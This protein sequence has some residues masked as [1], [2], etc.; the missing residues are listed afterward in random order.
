MRRNLSCE[1]VQM[2]AIPIDVRAAVWPIPYTVV[3]V[4]Y[5]LRPW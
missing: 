5:L 4:Q 2:I 3:R 1:N